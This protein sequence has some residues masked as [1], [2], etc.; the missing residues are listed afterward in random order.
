[1]LFAINY[2]VTNEIEEDVTP[3][4]CQ[5]FSLHRVSTTRSGAVC[6][7][8][9]QNT[10]GSCL[11]QI[12]DVDFIPLNDTFPLQAFKEW[13]AN[14][15]GWIYD[16]LPSEIYDKKSKTNYRQGKI[17]LPDNV[18]DLFGYPVKRW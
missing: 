11:T 16:I 7:A 8:P 12:T 5:L 13:E 15:E 10:P 1:M 18:V 2:T 3:T 9:P 6:Q 17:T 4:R 14:Q